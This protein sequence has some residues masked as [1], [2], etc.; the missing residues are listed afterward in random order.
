[1]PP[2][3]I[4]M[5]D[6]ARAAGV[7]QT[8]V[9]LALRND[10]RLPARTRQRVRAL[11]EKLGYRP[12]PMLSALNFYRASNH[13]VKSPPTMAFVFDFNQAREMTAS[14]PH[15]LFLEG[16]RQQ[17]AEMGYH[18]DVFYVGARGNVAGNL[19]R[20]LRARGIFGLI[21]AAFAG[22]SARVQLDWS[23]FSAVLIE[24]QQLGLSLHTVSNHQQAVTREAI[25]RLRA[26]GHRRIGLAVGAREE[27]YLKNAFTGGY[28]AEIPLW[29][30]LAPVPP[31]VFHGRETA[32]IVGELGAWVRQHAVEVVISNWSS[33]PQA[34]RLAGLRVPRDIVFTSLDLNPDLAPVAGMQQNHRIVGARAVE[35]LAGLMHAHARGLV[36]V[37]NLTL[38]EGTWVPARRQSVHK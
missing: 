11:A 2:H 28:R 19:Q 14:H 5:R 26:L 13:A 35:Q 1:M 37:P 21:L 25:R 33:V 10:P 27:M 17:A 22:E 15:R 16:A 20:V 34:L 8:T 18:L 38:I 29:P 23:H 32:E 6:V 9:S 3:R 12:D 31:L 30:D 4:T 7:H 24:S 36:E